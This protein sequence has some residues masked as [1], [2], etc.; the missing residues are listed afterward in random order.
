VY[1]V[2][3][4]GHSVLWEASDSDVLLLKVAPGG[5]HL[6]FVAGGKLWIR[7]LNGKAN[8]SRRLLTSSDSKVFIES[9]EWAKD[10]KRIAFVM[11]DNTSVPELDI[12]F[13]AKGREQVLNITR[14]F[15][16]DRTTRRRVGIVDI[17]GGDITWLERNE[18]DP[19]WG[20]GWSAAGD[21]LFVDSSDFLAKSREV[22]V[23]DTRTAQQQTYFKLHDSNANY[24]HW[25]AAWAP[26]DDGLLILSDHDGYYHLYHAR[27][28]ASDLVPLTNGKWEV[29]SFR[30]DSESSLIYFVANKDHVAD[31]QLYRIGLASGDIAEQISPR[32]GTYEPH[33]SPN[34]RHVAFRF[35]DDHTPPDLYYQRLR[36]A[37]SLLR[38][39]KSPQ[40]RFYEF[41]WADVQYVEF[42]SHVDGTQLA[43]RLYLPKDFDTARRYPLI[44]GSVYRDTV[45]N[46]WGGSQNAGGR[47]P[48]PTWGLTNFWYRTATLF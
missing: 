19:V 14:P 28:P 8:E 2:D 6:S 32:S 45:R 40:K 12:H 7:D 20:Y 36:D 3:L 38:I 43:G 10:G 22:L 26:D 25:A 11:A 21:A 24:P 48:H 37:K 35:S 23:Y 4:E 44:V 47:A 33:Y 13:F 17:V 46:Q 18:A 29:A 30:V 9:Y 42:N 27:H 1:A 16:G 15:P 39:T 34:F 41:Q 31:R 5:A